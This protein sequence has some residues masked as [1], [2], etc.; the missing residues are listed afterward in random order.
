MHGRYVRAVLHQHPPATDTVITQGTLPFMSW[1]LLVAREPITHEVH[2]DL[3]SFFYVLIWACVVLEGP[4]RYRRK[5][6]IMKTELQWW[7]VG[8]SIRKTGGMKQAHMTGVPFNFLLEDFSPYFEPIK[9]VIRDLRDYILGRGWHVY[10]EYEP[11]LEILIR[12]RDA[13]PQIDDPPPAPVR[14]E[15]EAALEHQPGSHE[16]EPGPKENGGDDFDLS[17]SGSCHLDD[18]LPTSVQEKEY[19][20]APR[21]KSSSRKVKRIRQE[22]DDDDYIPFTSGKDQ[23][24]IANPKSM[25]QSKRSRSSTYDSGALA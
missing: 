14:E 1:H 12:G 19:E 17:S 11:F 20:I 5:F 8:E 10:P 3:E 4:G 24:P 22:N 13:M 9:P 7:V 6:D 21:R 23:R 18:L 16:S 15:G 25:R 2:H